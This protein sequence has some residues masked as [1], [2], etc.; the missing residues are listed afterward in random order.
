[1][2]C[3]RERLSVPDEPTGLKPRRVPFWRNR[4]RRGAAVRDALSSRIP[5]KN[6]ELT[7]GAAWIMTVL[8]I[9]RGYAGEFRLWVVGER[10]WNPCASGLAG[11]LLR[12]LPARKNTIFAEVE[13]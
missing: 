1:M 6:G 10:P 3:A 11:R 13:L 5:W 7:R 9:S 12:R 8:E 2:E 4:P